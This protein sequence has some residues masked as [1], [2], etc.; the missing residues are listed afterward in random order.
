VKLPATRAS[1][2]VAAADTTFV[3]PMTTVTSIAV[4][5]VPAVALIAAVAR[6]GVIGAANA[7][8]WRLPD[9]MQHFRKLTTGHAIIMGRRTWESLR[10]AL[11]DR[12]NIVVT[13]QAD[14]AAAGAET[15]VSFAA[16]LA[17]VR[18]PAPAFCI[19]GGELYAVALQQ[20]DVLHLT[21]IARDF[22]GDTL[23]PAFDRSGW[24]ETAREVRRATEGFEYAF[25]TYVR[26]AGNAG[27]HAT[28]RQHQEQ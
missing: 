17:R 7:M 2:S 19:G 18:M 4:P 3:A 12:Q 26:A 1:A 16:A 11:P 8:P 13:R 9:D 21:E 23:F 24:R 15:A 10:R 27:T 20:A 6:N 25:V 14:Y 28:T 5:G 22:A